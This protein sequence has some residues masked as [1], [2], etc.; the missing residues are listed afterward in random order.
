[1]SEVKKEIIVKKLGL[2]RKMTEEERMMQLSLE[3]VAKKKK[4]LEKNNAETQR[5]SSDNSPV[6]LSYQ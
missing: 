5:L 6:C 2:F 1:M 4:R 3:E